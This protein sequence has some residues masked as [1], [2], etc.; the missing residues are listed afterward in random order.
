MS[1][2]S[3]TLGARVLAILASALATVHAAIVPVTLDSYAINA[4]YYCLEREL[5]RGR[6]VICSL[7][8]TVMAATGGGVLGDG[9]VHDMDTDVLQAPLGVGPPDRHLGERRAAD[10]S[11]P[12]LTACTEHP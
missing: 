10:V 6:F 1:N 3:T 4:Q 11:I 12:A 2:L 5:H 7:N 9:H 8:R